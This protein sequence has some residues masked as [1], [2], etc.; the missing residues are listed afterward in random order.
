MSI[1]ATE[2]KRSWREIAKR[3]AGNPVYATLFG[4][5][6]VLVLGEVLAPGFASLRQVTAQLTVAA[7][8]A[9]VA[10][11]Q[12]LVIL[13]GKEGIDLSVGSVMSL[14][15]LVA[16]NT[17]DGSSGMILPALVAATATGFAVGLFNGVGITIVRIAPLVMTLGTA[18]V[19]TGLLVALTQ[20]ATSGAAAPELTAFISRPFLFGIPGV[21]FVWAAVLI[22]MQFFLLRTRLGLAIYA[23]GSNDRAA[24]LAGIR[25]KLVRT[26]AFGLSGAFAG[27]AGFILLGY[28]GTVFVGA[29][30]QY[31]LPSVIAAVIGG[32]AL[33]GG[34]GNYAGT[35]A[36]AAFLTFLTA[37]LTSMSLSPADRQIVFGIVLIAFMA[38]YG[39]EKD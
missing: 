1:E 33:S 24:A 25:V 31:I 5:V 11:G 3:V 20:G 13:S 26:L 21:I 10:A 32:T 12:G 8:L 9:L 22:L 36:G 7:I 19:I 29:G 37:M 34:K 6:A 23:I 35:A 17:M 14:A 27:F 4:C 28:T 30:E 15:A 38:A 18:G 39:R 16:G 2:Q